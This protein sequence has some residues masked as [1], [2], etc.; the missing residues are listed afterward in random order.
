LEFII[1][2]FQD[3]EFKPNDVS[4]DDEETIAKEEG[5]TTQVCSLATLLCLTHECFTSA[6]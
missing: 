5:D 2:V 4:D 6:L 3:E 1:F